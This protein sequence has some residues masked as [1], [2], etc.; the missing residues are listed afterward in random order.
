MSDT[1]KEAL[2]RRIDELRVELG[3][4]QLN[5][6]M[7]HDRAEDMRN[8][9]IAAQAENAKLREY[10]ERKKGLQD[11]ARLVDENSKL[12]ELVSHMYECMCNIDADGNHECYSCEYE[13]GSCNFERL[14]R[15]LGM[16]VE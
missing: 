5:R 15:D 14:M 10:I 11:F 4:S 12:R 7:W 16:G 6:D 3:R 2:E 8:R 1:E 13:N 9:L